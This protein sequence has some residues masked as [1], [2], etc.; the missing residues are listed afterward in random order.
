[1]HAQPHGP[2]NLFIQRLVVRLR[3]INDLMNQHH[4]LIIQRR[5]RGESAR[6]VA[7]A[8]VHLSVIIRR[9][10][11]D[12]ITT[13]IRRRRVDT[14]P[15]GLSRDH[16]IGHGEQKRFV[17]GLG[18]RTGI[19]H[20][21]ELVTLGRARGGK[22]LSGVGGQGLVFGA[23][24]DRG[25]RLVEPEAV[26]RDVGLLSEFPGQSCVPEGPSQ[27]NTLVLRRR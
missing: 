24:P 17:V 12:A 7:Q 25:A 5:I 26:D 18:V 27:N 1:M 8:L 9:V 22:D 21:G 13:W 14:R 6:L 3:R 16:G 2:Q 20:D 4:G 23:V 19:H 11:A 10:I 15:A